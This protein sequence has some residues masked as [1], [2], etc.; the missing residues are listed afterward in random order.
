MKYTLESFSENALLKEVMLSLKRTIL[1]SLSLSLQREKDLHYCLRGFNSGLRIP[2]CKHAFRALFAGC[3]HYQVAKRRPQ[4]TKECTTFKV[5]EFDFWFLFG[6]VM[7]LETVQKE[8]G[9]ITMSLDFPFVVLFDHKR[10]EMMLWTNTIVKEQ[11]ENGTLH[12]VP[13]TYKANVLGLLRKRAERS[14]KLSNKQK[15]MKQDKMKKELRKN[16][17]KWP[18]KGETYVPFIVFI[19]IFLSG[20]RIWSFFSAFGKVFFFWRQALFRTTIFWNQ[21]TQNTA[22]ILEAQKQMYLPNTNS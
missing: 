3:E 2:C 7:E 17:G 15:I 18:I 21:K 14:K 22:P 9:L 11:D 12:V 8:K 13:S 19:G 6:D 5:D 4:N 10:Q 16:N 1:R 20:C